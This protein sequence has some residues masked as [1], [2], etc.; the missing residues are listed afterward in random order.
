MGKRKKVSPEISN[1]FSKSK[2]N[3]NRG[4][5]QKNQTNQLEEEE[6][7]DW[8]DLPGFGRRLEDDDENTEGAAYITNP[9]VCTT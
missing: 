9:V 1:P 7:F 8:S 3:R 4:K 6:G 5:R 2:R